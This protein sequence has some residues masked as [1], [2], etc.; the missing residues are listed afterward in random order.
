MAK[1]P[2][3]DKLPHDI[4]ANIKGII[5]ISYFIDNVKTWKNEN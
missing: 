3:I 2:L 1:S 5:M 4:R